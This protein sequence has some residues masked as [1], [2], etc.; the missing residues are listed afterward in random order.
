ML[1]EIL[2]LHAIAAIIS[3]QTLT[4]VVELSEGAHQQSS[5]HASCLDHLKTSFESLHVFSHDIPLCCS[6]KVI[7]A[8]CA[9]EK[10]GVSMS[11]VV[12]TWELTKVFKKGHVKAVDAVNL[13]IPKGAIYGLLGHNGAGKTTLL[14][15]LMGMLLPTAGGGTVVGYDMVKESSLVRKSVGFMPENYGLYDY[16][17]V[18]EFLEYLADLNGI[19]RSAA[20]TTIRML[21]EE[22][23]LWD[24]HSKKCGQLSRGMRQKLLVI[25]MLLKEPELLIMDEPT[26][27]LDPLAAREFKELI[28]RLS[29]KEG[30][31]IIFSTHLLQE[32]GG[33]C[34]HVGIM[35]MGK[36]LIQGEVENIKK[37]FLKKQ[38]YMITVEAHPLDEAYKLLGKQLQEQVALN[39]GRILIYAH[40][41]VRE[42]IFDLLASHGIK[43]R[44]LHLEIP[45][46]EQIFH[47]YYRGEC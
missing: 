19:P 25:S 2:A 8:P 5:P 11:Y 13:R 45:S 21:L 24:H 38:G 20:R 44:D 33:L 35:Y 43:V 28:V 40:S 6:W 9:N 26:L 36:L 12:E 1:V 41:D 39:R 16:M 34:S 42:A 31:T 3:E 47:K 37:R 7:T 29:A 23:N 22:F 14:H 30:K 18:D 46:L 15:L 17:K 10:G 27:G 32:I 4:S